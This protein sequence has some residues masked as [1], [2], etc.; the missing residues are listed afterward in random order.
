[1]S[2]I[3]TNQGFGEIPQGE[4]QEMASYWGLEL[5]RQRLNKKPRVIHQWCISS[6]PGEGCMFQKSSPGGGNDDEK[7]CKGRRGRRAAG[8]PS[9]GHCHPGQKLEARYMARSPTTMNWEENDR[10]G[11]GET[12]IGSWG[13]SRAVEKELGL[14]DG[15]RIKRHMVKVVEINSEP[16]K[17][18]KGS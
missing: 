16:G 13:P 3:S 4:T 2:C 18:K 15:Y 5:L 9:D 10:S 6:C 7:L 14:G 12:C 1:M 8:L 11:A 17:M